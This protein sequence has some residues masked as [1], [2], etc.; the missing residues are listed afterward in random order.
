MVLPP[1]LSLALE[2]TR[3]RKEPSALGHA[4]ICTFQRNSYQ[5][6]CDMI[7][8]LSYVKYMLQLCVFFI[9]R[10]MTGLRSKK[11]SQMKCSTN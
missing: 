1:P 8:T 5:L 7:Y 2:C 6:I 11:I 10:M 9:R 4:V 3:P